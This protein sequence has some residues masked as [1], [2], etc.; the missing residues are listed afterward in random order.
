MSFGGG[1]GEGLESFAYRSKTNTFIYL[2][3]IHLNTGNIPVPIHYYT[4][5]QKPQLLHLCVRTNCS[6]LTNVSFSANISDSPY[7]AV[8]VEDTK[9]YSL[10]CH[11][12]YKEHRISLLNKV[13]KYQQISLFFLINRNSLSLVG[14]VALMQVLSFVFSNLTT[15]AYC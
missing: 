13:D 10:S 3:K 9:H 12:Y 14:G 8:V 15:L 6:S 7:V 2:F 11:L 1:G 4:G 5:C